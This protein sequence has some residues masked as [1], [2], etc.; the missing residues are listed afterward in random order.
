MLHTFARAALHDLV[1]NDPTK[2]VAARLG[3]SDVA[4]SKACRKADIPTPPVGYWARLRAGKAT[5]RRPL[6]ARGI[7]CSDEVTIGGR[8]YERWTR[9]TDEEVLGPLPPS[10]EFS[11]PI[12]VVREHAAKML[13]KVQVRKSLEAAHPAIARLLAQDDE[14]R[15]KQLKD[16][17]PS[18]WDAPFFVSAFERRRLFILNALFLALSRAGATASI[19]GKDGRNVRLGVGDQSV[20]LHVD[21]KSA[22]PRDRWTES[23]RRPDPHDAKERLRLRIE[24]E[25][26]PDIR[27][28]WEDDSTR[29]VEQHVH[30]IAIELLVAAE[31]Q[32]RAGCHHRYQWRVERRTKL[33][34]EAKREREEAV[35]QERERR[36]R[37]ERSQVRRLLKEAAALR[38]ANDIRRYVADARLSNG[39]IAD[40]VPDAQFAAWATWALANA[41]RID[42]IV[43]RSFCKLQPTEEA[44]ADQP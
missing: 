19:Q 8:W 1:W 31:V 41:D 26:A 6:P 20:G 25:G 40:P 36:E 43:S 4:L 33:Q 29:K 12:S 22:K 32:Y 35:Q 21:A 13:R 7:G 2:T 27:T 24:V 10:P 18:S 37:F 23:W 30:E 42:P 39:S 15:E 28:E 17:Y 9:M 14:R 38:T 16:S 44:A 5:E 34:E 11:E 3:V